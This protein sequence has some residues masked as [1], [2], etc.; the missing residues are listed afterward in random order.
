MTVAI[1]F[2]AAGVAPA[3]PLAAIPAN[4]YKVAITS[5]EMKPAKKQGNSFIEVK[6][7]VLEGEFTGRVLFDRLNVINDNQ[8]AMDIANGQLSS[9]CRATGVSNL[10]KANGGTGQLHGIPFMIKVGIRPAGKGADGKDYGPQN[11]IEDY[12]NLNGRPL[13]EQ[14]DG[15]APPGWA[16]NTATTQQAPPPGAQLPPPPAPVKTMTAA[17]NGATY[18]AMIA[19]G[20]TD[21][22]LVQNGM[23]TVAAPTPPPPRPPAPPAPG[24]APPPPVAAAAGGGAKPPWL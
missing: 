10:T 8:Q 19:I 7:G 13:A 3:A 23:M 21:E 1:D 4:W 20:W 5:T 16:G 12:G 11:E 22:T 6:M 15:S 24:Q 17:A 9:Y 2:N 18:E 14:F